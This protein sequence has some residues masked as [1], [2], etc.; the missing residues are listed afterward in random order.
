MLLARYLSDS[1]NEFGTATVMAVSRSLKA[2]YINVTG[3]L[4]FDTAT[5]LQSWTELP[6]LLSLPMYRS[7]EKCNFSPAP[8]PIGVAFVFVVD[9]VNP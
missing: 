7:Y 5:R 9:N 1:S 6:L 2:V 4:T 8:S 3:I